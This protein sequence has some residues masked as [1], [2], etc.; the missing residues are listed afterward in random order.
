MLFIADQL[1]RPCLDQSLAGG[2]WQQSFECPI[3]DAN[4][5]A[6]LAVHR[7]PNIAVVLNGPE[8]HRA[9]AL[10]WEA[11]L[12]RFGEAQIMLDRLC[13]TMLARLSR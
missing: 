9:S 8:A 10:N 4:S 1:K 13:F 7:W 5:I 11:S 2:T 3:A 6:E 12:T